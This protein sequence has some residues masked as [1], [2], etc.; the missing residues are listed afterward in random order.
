MARVPL[1]GEL[2]ETELDVVPVRAHEADPA[3]ELLG[4]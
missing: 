4:P 2:P 1:R 3:V